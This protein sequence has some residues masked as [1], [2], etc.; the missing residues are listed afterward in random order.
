MGK[1]DRRRRKAAFELPGVAP[2][3]KPKK[4]GSARMAEIRSEEV[5]VALKARA[6]TLGLR[7]ASEVT[8]DGRP[9]EGNI[10]E[11]QKRLAKMGAQMLG[12]RAGQALHIGCKPEEATD[13]YE[14][15]VDMTAAEDRYHKSLGVSIHAKSAKIEMMPERTE[16]RDDDRP[17][18]RSEEERDM[19]AQAAWR[20]WD[21]HLNAIGLGH[22]SAIDTARQDFAPLLVDATLSPAGER[23][24][25]AM[26]AL[27]KQLKPK[28]TGQ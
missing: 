14:V 18:L 13:L 1:G 7:L 16:T 5:S 20:R 26:R 28:E 9:H 17:D 24:I 11:N 6:R 25:A 22:R 10:R 23:F 3:K 15:W 4:R 27:A 19:A 21:G 12:E 8:R 2:V